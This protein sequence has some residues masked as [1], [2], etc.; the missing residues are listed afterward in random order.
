VIDAHGHG[1]RVLPRPVQAVRR[2]TVRGHPADSPLTDLVP[3][4]VDAVVAN[5]VG[6]RLVTRWWWPAD[7]WAAVRRQLDELRHEA[8]TAGCLLATSLADI[9]AARRTGRPAV[10]L[11]LEGADI[12]GRDP[13]RLAAVHAAGV[14]IIGLVHF[15]DNAL[16]TTAMSLEPTTAQ[17]RGTRRPA[18]SRADC[19]RCR[20]RGRD[21]Q[22]RHPH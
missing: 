7:S 11:G 10:V 4:G 17:P 13:A 5:A 19:T 3:A 15:A 16:G 20:G 14:R 8:K 6:D 2:V 1:T 22:T 12:L 21:E 18:R 9:Q